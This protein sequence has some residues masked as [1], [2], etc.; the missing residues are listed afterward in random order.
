MPNPDKIGAQVFS[1]P[2]D[3]A[4]MKSIAIP[5]LFSLFAAATGCAPGFDNRNASRL[6]TAQVPLPSGYPLSTQFLMQAMGHWDH[7]A[8]GVAENCARALT[9]FYPEEAVPVYVPEV[10]DTPFAR[11]YREFLLTRLVDHGVPIAFSPEGAAVLEVTT[12]MVA[13]HRELDRASGHRVAVDPGFTQSKD[14][15]GRYRKTPVIAEESGIFPAPVP[16]TEFQINSALMYR[17][18]C[19]YR[20]SS[21]FYVS[22]R[23]WNQYQDTPPAGSGIKR[24]TL[25]RQ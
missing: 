24:F 20:D 2:V 12:A 17:N 4:N 6:A 18:A 25:V 13:H 23:D 15:R 7:Q 5:V 21:V 3:K 9:H 11:S 1:V 8:A 22:P 14:E 19:L 10:G 16:Q